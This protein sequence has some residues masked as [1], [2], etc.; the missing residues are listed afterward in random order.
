MRYS[1]D[2]RIIYVKLS[3]AS[4][5]VI[6]VELAEHVYKTKIPPVSVVFIYILACRMGQIRALD[7]SKSVLILA[8]ARIGFANFLGTFRTPSNIR[9]N[10]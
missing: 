2:S 8:I 10:V 1:K 3:L 6:K 4:F 7:I 5:V 9:A